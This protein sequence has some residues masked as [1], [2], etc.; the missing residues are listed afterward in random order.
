MSLENGATAVVLADADVP[1]GEDVLGI[2][3]VELASSSAESR[4]DNGHQR[5]PRRGDFNKCQ[6]SRPGDGGDITG[7]AFRDDP[8]MTSLSGRIERLLRASSLM[9]SKIRLRKVD[10]RSS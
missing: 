2:C 8:S 4:E 10:V 9:P 7:A 1:K 3:R 6:C 5:I